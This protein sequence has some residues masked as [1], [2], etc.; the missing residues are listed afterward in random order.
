M[1]ER[2]DTA[3]PRAWLAGLRQRF[4]ALLAGE[5]PSDPLYLSNR[6]WKQK[7]RL[8]AL[9]GIP[10][11]VIALVIV[12]ASTDVFQLRRANPYD[13]PGS[14]EPAA[15]APDPATEP[16]EKEME[17]SNLRIARDVKPPI[18]TGEFRNNS[19]HLIHSAEITYFIAD[20][21]GSLLATESTEVLEVGPHRVV[22][23]SAPLKLSQAGYVQVR[24]VHAN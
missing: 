4:D 16:T 5:A 2:R 17:V 13:H 3:A 24:D 11:L 12:A 8:A 1:S 9:I 22:T 7:L 20:N 6:T 18:I 23:F 15:T 21:N 14:A 10:M 19:D